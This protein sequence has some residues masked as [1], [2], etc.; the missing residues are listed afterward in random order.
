MDPTSIELAVPFGCGLGYPVSQGHDTGSHVLNDMWAWDFRMPSGVP[1]VAALDGTVRLA[2]GDSTE[3]G[4]NP[5][6]ASEAN[7]VVLA[8]QNGLETQYLHLESV[9]V[10]PGDRIQAG[11]ILGYSGKTG[12]ACGSHLHFKLAR[13]EGPGWNNPSVRARIRGYGDPTIETVVQA[14]PCSASSLYAGSASNRAKSTQGVGAPPIQSG[15][16][17]VS[18]VEP[19]TNTAFPAPRPAAEGTGATN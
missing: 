17:P 6:F 3:G 1:I 2:R 15:G 13:S 8:H 10:R 12:W 9:T 11:D 14:A 5:A 7:Y 16:A 19:R 18:S 4:C